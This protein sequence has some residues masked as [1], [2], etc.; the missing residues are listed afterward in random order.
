MTTLDFMPPA[1][2]AADHEL[3]NFDSG[4]WSLNEW[5]KKR[6]FKNHASGASRCFVLCVGATV[7]GYYSLSAGAI[8]HAAALKAMR[9][10]MPDP[11]PVLLLGR[12]AVDKHHHNQGIGQALLRDAMLRAVNVAGDAGV[13]ALLV[14]AISDQARQFYLSR[15]F[16]ESPLQPMTLLMTIETIR[17]ILAEPD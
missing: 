9:R 17:S 11:L 6:A 5:L 8:S 4:E 14:H 12:L 2:I 13:F 1:P 16:V 3:A 10:N 7:I 15:G